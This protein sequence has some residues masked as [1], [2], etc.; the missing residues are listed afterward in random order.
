MSKSMSSALFYSCCE[1]YRH[2]V[3]THQPAKKCIEFVECKCLLLVLP[4]DGAR[5]RNV[6]ERELGVS[7]KSEVGKEKSRRK[8][9]GTLEFNS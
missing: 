6:R 3:W 8:G 9:L 5:R 1:R 2:S 4:L 7:R